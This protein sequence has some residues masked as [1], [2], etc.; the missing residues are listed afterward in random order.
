VD[1]AAVGE[2]SAVDPTVVNK[3]TTVQVWRRS[4][5]ERAGGGEIIVVSVRV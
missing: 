1:P 2:A 4:R 5:S 3:A